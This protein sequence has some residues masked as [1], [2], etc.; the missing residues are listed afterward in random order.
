MSRRLTTF[1][2]SALLAGAFATAPA[3]AATGVSPAR[4]FVPG[5]VVVKLEGQ[6]VGRSVDLPPGVGVHRATAALRRRPRVSYAAPN[7]IATASATKPLLTSTGI[8]NDPGPIEGPPGAPGGWTSLQWNL[9]PWEGA[10]TA[11]LPTSPGGIDAVGAWQNLIEAK[12]P[13]AQGIVVAVLDTGVAYRS[14]SPR[15]LRSPDFATGQFVKGYDFVA[16]DSLPLDENG[17]G[18]HIAGTIGEKTDNGIGLAGLAYRAKLMPVRVLDKHGAGEADDIARGIRFAVDNGADVI[19]MSFNFGCGKR[20]PGINEELR[21]AYEKGVVTVASVGNLGAETCVSPPST[22][23]RVIGVGGATEGG[24]LGGYSLTGD[25]ID[26]VAPGGGAPVPG[27]PSV[28]SRPIYQVT[29]KGGDTRRFGEPANYVGTSM[30]A[31]HVSGVAAMVLASG[32]LPPK[33]SPR[34]TVNRVARRLGA[35][36]RNL[37]LAAT[38][39][40]AGLIDAAAA[41]DPSL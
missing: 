30:A 35:T 8:P 34:G 40:G 23:P 26:V 27:C 3:A 18:T 28:W 14:M 15:F 7:Y 22:G 33:T 4:A 31:A 6:R 12:R 29:L 19:N 24:C 2:A 11:L 36:A 37:G 10:P 20:V 5:E 17:H 25:G 9:L 38:R 32:V 21:R 39:Q 1:A 41:T 13:G 16:G